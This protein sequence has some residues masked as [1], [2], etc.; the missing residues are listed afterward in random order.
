MATRDW[1]AS[2]WTKGSKGELSSNDPKKER[3]SM[4]FRSS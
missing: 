1:I 4:T 3:E 2:G